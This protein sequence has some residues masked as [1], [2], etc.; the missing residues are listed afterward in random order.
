M[1]P[2]MDDDYE[3]K[4][5]NDESLVSIVIPTHNRKEHIIRLLESIYQ[6]DYPRNKLE[7]IVVDDVSTDDTENAIKKNFPEVHIIRNKLE[8][9]SSLSRNVGIKNARAEF[10]FFIDDDNTIDKN[11]I[12]ELVKIL[13]SDEKVCCVGPLMYFYCDKK[14][15][16]WAGAKRG[17]LTSLTKIFTNTPSKS[18]IK[19]EY[20]PN[21][22]MVRKKIAEKIGYFDGKNFPF[23]YDDGDF[24]Q[25]IK[26]EGYEIVFTLEAKVW[27]D[28]ALPENVK[29]KTRLFHCSSEEISISQQ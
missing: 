9:W 13:I 17:K 7:L 28:I 14:R 3:N 10:V 23:L 1:R 27:H 18:V 8:L 5:S 19:T 4:S 2:Q 12:K 24:C 11:C 21:A 20:I 29:E 22:F 6:S 26:K 25:R 15:I 16:A